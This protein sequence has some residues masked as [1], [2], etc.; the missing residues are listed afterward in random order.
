[1]RPQ[2]DRENEFSDPARVRRLRQVSEHYPR[3]PQAG[4]ILN[5]PTGGSEDR[6]W[7]RPS[8]VF[9]HGSVRAWN[10]AQT[11]DSWINGLMDQRMVANYKLAEGRSGTS[12]PVI[13]LIV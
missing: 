9:G 12:D 1:M 3:P 5:C 7:G 11:M 4:R 10:R 13:R 6:Q 8:K 2:T